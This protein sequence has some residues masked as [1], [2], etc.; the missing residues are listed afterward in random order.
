[1]SDDRII[2]RALKRGGPLTDREARVIAN[3]W[4]GGQDSALYEFVSTGK[5][6]GRIHRELDALTAHYHG[7]GDDALSRAEFDALRAYVTEHGQRGRVDGW[8]EFTSF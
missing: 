6:S 2:R 8:V 1:M 7:N 4:H 3:G 5:I